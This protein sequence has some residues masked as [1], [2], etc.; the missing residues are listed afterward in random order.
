M[1]ITSFISFTVAC[2]SWLSGVSQVTCSGTA[3]DENDQPVP[4]IYI[5]NKRSGTGSFGNAGGSFTIDCLKEDT[6][7]IGALGYMP[8]YVCM[9]DSSYKREYTF[10]IYLERKFEQL[11]E[12]QVFAPRDL[13][14][15]KADINKLGY[16]KTDYMLSGIDAAQSPITFLYQQ[17]SR[18]EK[19]KRLVAQMENEDRKRELLKELFRI[20]V[21]WEIIALSNEEFDAFTDFINVSDEFMRASSQYDFLV[22]VKERFNDYKRWK[23][24]QKLDES[25]Y[26]Y[27]RD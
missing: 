25:D 4:N 8:R 18:K 17:F 27:N 26:D 20:Y 1:K 23:R 14:K 3:R 11:A 12:V 10:L 19:S 9:K 13:E 21:D 15:I 6:L 24:G 22:Y 2:L 7:M 16:D 5:I